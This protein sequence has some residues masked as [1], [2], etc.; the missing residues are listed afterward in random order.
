[1]PWFVEVCKSIFPAEF[2]SST[3]FYDLWGR[4]TSSKY[5]IFFIRRGATLLHVYLPGRFACQRH[6]FLMT[7]NFIERADGRRARKPTALH[8]GTIHHQDLRLHMRRHCKG[9]AHNHAT[10]IAL[11]CTFSFDGLLSVLREHG[12][13][14]RGQGVVIFTAIV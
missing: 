4:L 6:E 5:T 11:H 12:L 3:V 14:G 2:T 7:R 9:Q 13:P 10:R 8:L 1:M